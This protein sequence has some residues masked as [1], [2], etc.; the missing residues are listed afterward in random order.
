ME[1][2]SERLSRECLQTSIHCLQNSNHIPRV[3][4]NGLISKING[5]NGCLFFKEV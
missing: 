3:M 2:R 1:Q 5:R 4:S